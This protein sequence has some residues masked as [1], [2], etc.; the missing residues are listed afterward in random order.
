MDNEVRLVMELAEKGSAEAQHT[1]G[2]MYRSGEGVDVNL[3]DAVT[4][5]KKAAKQNYA[6]AQYELGNIYYNGVDDIPKD[7]EQAV[8]WY[9]KA[10]IQENANAKTD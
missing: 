1:L 4:W 7:A 3:E 5:L 6:E 8:F 10:V 9:A 2:L